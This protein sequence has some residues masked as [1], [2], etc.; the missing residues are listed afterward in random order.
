MGCSLQIKTDV[1][2]KGEFINSL[3]QKILTAA[4]TDI[5]DVLKFVDWVDG[6][7]SSLVS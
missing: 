2:T 1:E 4:F 7:L 5:E 3:I 6:E